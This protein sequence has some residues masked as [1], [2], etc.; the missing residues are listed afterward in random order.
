MLCLRLLLSRI[1]SDATKREK[2]QAD[3]SG[4]ARAEIF[5]YTPLTR[6]PQSLTHPSTISPQWIATIGAKEQIKSI[7]YWR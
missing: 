2:L 6:S 3:N 4:V 5:S 1:V 7:T